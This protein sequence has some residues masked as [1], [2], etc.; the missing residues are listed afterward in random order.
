[1]A[2]ALF[3]SHP[4]MR[5]EIMRR[6]ALLAILVPVFALALPGVAGAT[7]PEH[8]TFDF[9]F[10]SFV[11]TGGGAAAP[12]QFECRATQHEYGRFTVFF[13]KDGN[14]VKAMIHFN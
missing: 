13:D 3:R 11:D 1:M 7:P 2:I 12:G 6:V 10:E 9:G 14:F 8:G 4:A 5:E